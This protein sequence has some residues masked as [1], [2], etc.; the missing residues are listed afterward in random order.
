MNKLLIVILSL[1]AMAA[2]SQA[3]AVTIDIAGIENITLLD[4]DDT[5][6]TS[7]HQFITATSTTSGVVQA[8][9][10]SIKEVLTDDYNAALI[11]YVLSVDSG[12]YIDISFNDVVTGA[13]E[14]VFLFAGVVDDPDPSIAEVIIN[15]D[16]EINGTRESGI[17]PFIPSSDG[18]IGEGLMDIDGVNSTLTASIIDLGS[19]GLAPNQELEAFR[20][21]MAESGSGFPALNGVGYIAPVPLPLPVILFASGLGML[22]LFGRRKAS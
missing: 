19:F 15:F 2:S 18:F 6:S 4:S 21:Y 9:D 5:V 11:T 12:A 20:I 1:T 22:G 17:V 14:L 16:L 13:D 7:N 10:P 3:W 8:N